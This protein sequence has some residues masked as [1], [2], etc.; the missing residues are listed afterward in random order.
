[1]ASHVKLPRVECQLDCTDDQ[2]TLVKVMAWCH[3]ATSH[4][5]SQCWPRSLAPY[6][7]T[8]PQWVKP[9]DTKPQQNTT[10]CELWTKFLQCTMF[11]MIIIS[12]CWFKLLPI[13]T[14][15]LMSFCP[16][17]M[18]F[19]PLKLWFCPLNHCHFCLS[20]CHFVPRSCCQFVLLSSSILFLAWLNWW[21]F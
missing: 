10:K 3:Q 2:S 8:R 11:K 18:P 9:V 1:M 5:L 15:K 6:G 14:T 16:P 17:W 21:L 12:K 4:Y 7:I 19:Y 13:N 20:C